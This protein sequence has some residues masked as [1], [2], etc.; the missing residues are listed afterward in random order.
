MEDIEP[1][2]RKGGELTPALESVEEGTELLPRSTGE[3]HNN[4]GRSLPSNP[5]M[6]KYFESFPGAGDAYAI[7]GGKPKAD[8]SGLDEDEG[9]LKKSKNN[10]RLFRP[11][12]AHHKNKAYKERIKG[13]EAKFKEGDNLNDFRIQVH[14][15]FLKHGLDTISYVPDLADANT[16][17]SVVKDLPRFIGNLEKA[18]TVAT[19]IQKK[20]DDFDEDNSEAAL[21]FL[22]NSLDDELARRLEIYL[23]PNDSFAHGWL[24]LMSL[25]VSVSSTHYENVKNKV[26]NCNPRDYAQENINQMTETMHHLISE[27]L[28]ANQ[29]DPGLTLS[30]LQ[31]ISLTCSQKG[32]FEHYLNNKIVEVDKEVSTCNYMDKLDANEHMTRKRLDPKSILSFLTLKYNQL[33]KDD[34]WTPAKNP[35]DST[36]PTLAN[37]AS[38][39][40]PVGTSDDNVLNAVLNLLQANVKAKTNDKKKTP[41]NSPCHICGKLGHWAPDCPQKKQG[42]NAKNSNQGKATASTGKGSQSWRRTRP[43]DGQPESK[44][45]NGK[46]YFWC[47]KCKRW[48]ASHGTSTHRGSRRNKEDSTSDVNLAANLTLDP[49]VWNVSAFDPF[50][51][52]GDSFNF[53]KMLL[54]IGYFGM[55][56]YFLP[57]FGLPRGASLCGLMASLINAFPILWSWFQTFMLSSGYPFLV[58][59]VKFSYNLMSH[60]GNFPIGC[61]LAPGLWSLLFFA[62]SYVDQCSKQPPNFPKR[63]QRVRQGRVTDYHVN[64]WYRQHKRKHIQKLSL[65]QRLRAKKKEDFA[66]LVDPFTPL[67]FQTTNRKRASHHK[68]K[69]HSAK[70]QYGRGRKS[71]NHNS[72]FN[73]RQ[74]ESLGHMINDYFPCPSKRSQNA[75]SSLNFNH[76]V[77]V[78]SSSGRKSKLHPVNK[79]NYLPHSWSKKLG[80]QHRL[81]SR[82]FNVSSSFDELKFFE[83]CTNKHASF[84]IIWDSGASVCVTN[85]REDF[86][87]FSSDVSIRTLGG[88]ARGQEGNVKGEGYVIWSIEDV[89]GV[90]RTL[91]LKAYYLPD[92]RV[93]L[94]STSTVISSYP[95]ETFIIND[96][97]GRLSGITNNPCRGAI[98]APK[99]LSSNLLVSIG[100]KYFSSSPS[101]NIA[102][103]SS[104]IHDNHNL[105]GAEKEL[106]RWHERLAHLA[107]SKVKFLLRSGALAT[108][109]AARRLQRSAAN[110]PSLKC[111]ACLF[112]KQRTRSAPGLTNV[113]H[114]AR[115]GVLKNNNLLPG[116][117]VSVD[118]FICSQK[119]RLFSS[120]GRS[121]DEDMYKG[122]CLFIDHA[123]NFVHI[124]FQQV[125]TT[126]ATLQSKIAFEE[127]CRDHGVIPLKY[128]SDN[129]TAFTGSSFVAHLKKFAQT[130]RYAGV[131]AHHH[132]GHAERSIQTIMS[133]AR[134]MMIHSSMH[135]PELA[136]TSLWPMAVQHAAFLWNRVPD[137]STGLSPLDIFSKSRYNLSKFHDIHVWGSPIYVLDKRIADGKKLPRWTPRSSRCMYV[138]VAPTYASTVPLVLN[139]STGSITPQFHVVFDDNFTTVNADP[140]KLPDYNSEE[141]YKLF[142][143]STLQYP[144]DDD[145]ASLLQELNSELEG[146]VS[147]NREAVA[148]DRVLDAFEQARP[149]QSLGTPPLVP[150]TPWRESVVERQTTSS[151]RPAVAS[152]RMS[153]GSNNNSLSVPSTSINKPTPSSSSQPSSVVSTSDST[154][155]SATT[156]II[157]PTIEPVPK[158]M[159]SP[160]RTRSQSRRVSHAAS[161]SVRRSSRIAE[162][163]AS[164][165]T[166]QLCFDMPPASHFELFFS[167]IGASSV[168]VP[169]LSVAK[170][171]DPD[172][173]TFDEA[174]NSEYR[175]KWIEAATKELRELEE[176]KSWIEVLAEEA[177]GEKAVPVTWVF[178][179]K[180]APDGRIKRFKARFCVRGD[181]MRGVTDTYAPV[182]AFPTVRLFLIMSIL[183]GWDTC[184]IDF[185]NA[186]IQATRPK[187]I[188]IQ[189][190]RGFKPSQPGYILKLIRSLYGA[191]DAPRLWTELLFKAFKKFG[192]KQSAIDPCLWLRSDFFLICFVDD[193]GLCF[194]DASVLDEFIQFMTN[195]NF[196]LTKEETFAE[197]LGIQYKKVNSNIHLT[198]E[199]LISKIINATGL[200]EC[201][202]NRVPSASEPLGINPDGEPMSETWDYASV[203]GMLLYLS[204]N[205]RPDIAFAVSQ[206]ARFTHSPKQSHA[207]AVKT[208][209]RYLK[210][211]KD[212]GTIVQQSSELTLHC[213]ADADFAGLFKIDPPESISSAK[214]RTGYII[215]V[216]GCP[217]VWKSQLQ[218]TV[219]LSTA[220]S[221]YYA[222]SQSMRVLIP[223]R[224]MLDEMCKVIGVGR[225]LTLAENCIRATVFEDNTSA[226]RL[227]TEHQITARTRHYHARYHFF[228]DEVR[229]GNVEV[230]FVE[231]AAQDADYLTKIL[232]FEIYANNRMRV[233]GW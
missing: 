178:K 150:P 187:P 15:S 126:H 117:E 142:G 48:T 107:F 160:P 102:S 51:P 90:L 25:L 156:P 170:K 151:T 91:K 216:S 104:T 172:L 75:A 141:W 145:D 87:S 166:V 191:K 183:L 78:M 208:I 35:I 84:P 103:I 197:F 14:N 97:G 26:R 138:G 105:S 129:G 114:Q 40:I 113:V 185:S 7:S 108:T 228:W 38:T 217:L 2:V 86:I 79:N 37:V 223:I 131:G 71:Y 225:V 119:G 231:S 95:G 28:S 167:A 210:A 49:S 44:M 194:K 209:V 60:L 135:W 59:A 157:K 89:N 199:G 125:L 168:C 198:Q 222:L 176:H 163:N 5:I 177:N 92:C 6:G 109:E 164:K 220:E 162:R 53:L 124:E 10:P 106:L 82:A 32:L 144:L 148:R 69:P 99:N 41:Q 111:A 11:I 74:K 215:K 204:T 94:L 61:L 143:D 93:H 45:H 203:V 137:P 47:E 29:Y 214:S 219:A 17:Y 201:K 175:E 110:V 96:E 233:Q 154:S 1:A 155:S 62:I 139:P 55:C 224:A 213:Y 147:S 64:K 153:A 189:V 8:W 23:E 152:R 13:L 149:S 77:D 207:S 196:K 72:S 54:I 123:S 68:Q 88:Y 165:A 16:V 81:K 227:A 146:A 31:N 212:K 39:C 115:S 232:S 22:I 186:F 33:L 65:R 73:Q 76:G 218:T 161:T 200:S 182:V 158:P 83:N 184:S 221:E 9:A 30:M 120:R 42:S 188:F 128:I 100:H 20:Y 112:A 46:E 101:I 230:V 171:S 52:N 134:A 211:T 4:D 3:V 56:M 18:L 21:E 173:F 130:T 190:P 63:K 133:I 205:T 180:R 57:T 193:C 195:E 12:S 136:D 58:E 127:V 19:E 169:T 50:A 132:N 174:M 80:K 66:K 118:H 34:L 206:V 70:R 43:E 226:L 181:L 122:G 202:P 36:K 98:F 192:L 140:S 229:V 27:L 24:R 85:C 121:K 116:Q 179:I 67:E 159:S